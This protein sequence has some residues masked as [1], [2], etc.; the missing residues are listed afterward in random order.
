M[1]ERAAKTPARPMGGWLQVRR[2]QNVPRAASSLAT[3]L[4]Q[5]TKQHPVYIQHRGGHTAYVN[6]RRCEAA[7]I[8]EKTPEPARRAALSETGGKSDRRT[9]RDGH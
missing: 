3:D 9:C 5:A 1:R 4:D 7:D 2:H 8:N 6:S